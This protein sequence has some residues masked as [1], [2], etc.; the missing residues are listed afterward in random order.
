MWQSFINWIPEIR[1]TMEELE[2][3]A[4]EE[5]VKSIEGADDDDDDNTVDTNVIIWTINTA[6][7]DEILEILEP[8]I[9]KAGDKN[10][11]FLEVSKILETLKLDDLVCAVIKQP[12]H[13]LL[14]GVAL[15]KI[16]TMVCNCY[17]YRGK[18]TIVDMMVNTI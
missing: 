2:Q 10:V 1:Y 4:P 16:E 5:G 11:L 8:E 3:H 15:D 13:Y 7:K 18:N 9:L 17:G 14:R 12:L 6:V